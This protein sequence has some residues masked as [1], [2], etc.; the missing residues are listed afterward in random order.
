MAHP[1]SYWYMLLI[2]WKMAI[3]TIVQLT[4]YG[5]QKKYLSNTSS[6]HLSQSHN[7]NQYTLKNL[8]LFSFITSQRSFTCQEVPKNAFGYLF[9]LFMSLD[10]S[11]VGLNCYPFPSKSN[12][13]NA[14]WILKMH[15]RLTYHTFLYIQHHASLL[16]RNFGHITMEN[17]RRFRIQSFQL[18]HV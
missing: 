4:V 9:L 16:L 11:I 8:V 10:P 7:S 14:V 15:Y 3:S 1:L 17:N 18:E 2:W 6:S 5:W 12:F 13:S